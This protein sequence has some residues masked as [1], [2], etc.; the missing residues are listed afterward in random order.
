[1]LRNEPETLRS[2]LA[3]GKNIRPRAIGR[4]PGLN[5]R[6]IGCAVAVD[7]TLIVSVTFIGA[8]PAGKVDGENVAVAPG[9]SP[10]TENVSAAPTLGGVT[11]S[12]KVA[13]PP[14]VTLTVDDPPPTPIE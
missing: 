2:L 5:G 3:K 11:R 4:L 9:G 12:V 8:E 10:L 14:G 6:S 1:M 7:G 13:C